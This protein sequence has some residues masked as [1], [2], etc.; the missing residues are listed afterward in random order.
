[1]KHFMAS[2]IVSLLTSITVYAVFFDSTIQQVY[3]NPLIMAFII[4]GVV[5]LYGVGL[6]FIFDKTHNRKNGEE[7]KNEESRNK[8]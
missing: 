6:G 7:S 1:M 2:T 5:M 8:Q 3:K 4:F